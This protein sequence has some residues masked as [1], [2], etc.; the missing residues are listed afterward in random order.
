MGMRIGTNI[1]AL[2]AQQALVGTKKSMDQ[3]MNR[4]SSGERINKASDDAVGLALSENFKSQLRGLKQANRNAQDGISMLQISEG[5]L[6][7]ITNMLVRLRELGIQSASDTIGDNERGMVEIEYQQLLSEVDRV[8]ASTEFNGTPLLSGV[9][10]SIDF[11]I[12]TKNSSDIDRISYDPAT[13]NAGTA[14][15]GIDLCTVATK[16][17]SQNSLAS[18]D[19]ALNQVNTVRSNLGAMQSRLN[20]TVEYLMQGVENVASAKSR[21]SDTD[22]AAD[23]SEYAKQNLLMQSGTAMLAQANQQN[24]M[25]LSLLQKS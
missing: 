11:Q 14:A 15:L 17:D 21:I 24:Q 20:S 13:T 3:A 23:S 19:Q 18:I 10:D 5:G 7:E 1:I 8:A 9:G 4:L 25:A 22:M 6:N 16:L 12:N 2:K